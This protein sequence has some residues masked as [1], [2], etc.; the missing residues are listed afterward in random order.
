MVGLFKI[1]FSSLSKTGKILTFVV[2][3][4]V[5]LLA[6]QSAKL[7][8]SEYLRLKAI[9]KQF[10]SANKKIKHFEQKEEH[11]IS[12]NYKNTKNTINKNKHINI[13]LKQDEKIIDSIS[14]SDDERNKFISKYENKR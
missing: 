4:L 13:K 2:C 5:L 9:E 3:V 1:W 7:A 8:R 14:V 10:V 11:I 6:V 12:K